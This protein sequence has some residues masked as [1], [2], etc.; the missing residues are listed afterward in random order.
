M[1]RTRARLDERGEGY[2]SVLAVVA[3]ILIALLVWSYLAI[4]LATLLIHQHPVHLSFTLRL[5]WAVALAPS[6]VT[7]VAGAGTNGTLSTFIFWAGAIGLVLGGAFTWHRLRQRTRD[8]FGGVTKRF[9]DSDHGFASPSEV[10][11]ILSAR[12]AAKKATFVRPDLGEIDVTRASSFAVHYGKDKRS[13]HEIWTS[14]EDTSLVVGPPRSGKGVHLA[15]PQ[16]VAYPGP[17]VTTSTRPDTFERT[18]RWRNKRGPVY[19]FDPQQQVGSDEE[20]AQKYPGV[21]LLRWSPIQGCDDPMRAMIRANSLVTSAGFGSGTTTNGDFWA[22]RA[23]AVMRPYLLA[24]AVG[25][26]TVK[27][28]Q[29]WAAN[30]EDPEPVSLLRDEIERR[31]TLGENAEV[32]RRW[33]DDLQTIQKGD[34]KLK[35]DIWAGVSNALESLSDP[36]VADVCSPPLGEEF[37]PEEF[38]SSG[39]GRPGTI[40]I[41][42]STSS[43]MTVAP[44]VAALIEDI[45]EQAR[46]I[47]KNSPHGRLVP[48]LS[49]QLDEAANIAPLPSLPNLVTDG[50]G[51]GINVS[52]FLQSLAQARE[53][54][55][56]NGAQTIMDGCAATVVLGGGKVP[57]DLQDLSTL[58]GT[59]KVEDVSKSRGAGG[60]ST[61]TS[62]REVA[63][64]PPDHIRQL[65]F[66][67]ALMVYRG[68][69]AVEVQMTPYSQQFWWR[70][71]QNASVEDEREK[72]KLAADNERI[73]AGKPLSPSRR[74]Q[75]R[76]RALHDA[77]T[78][79]PPSP[80]QRPTS[81]R[82]GTRAPASAGTRQ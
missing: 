14:L 21:R 29:R 78:T 68:A 79:S 45:V 32:Y 63:V 56:N 77:A 16:L 10:G 39:D 33:A 41:V 82:A 76:L 6:K 38:L 30:P 59:V 11:K 64:A 52:I 46:L 62:M 73:A 2:E 24:A 5:L 47:A 70:R 43:Q 9:A 57:S 26:K 18:Y 40:Y 49:L 67:T 28:I 35:G 4:E 71:A 69:Q 58:I 75:L 66:G 51:T 27:D 61:S 12:A 19:L 3:G 1:G 81:S 60:L 7:G 72:K 44:L 65:P 48:P 15:I 36:R 80:A 42:G 13:N 54:W 20:L 25:H 37:I 31:Q 8:L 22:K 53:C 23:T 34:H 50:G 17:V 74:L 55:G